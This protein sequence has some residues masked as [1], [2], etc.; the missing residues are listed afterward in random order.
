M[1]DALCVLSYLIFTTILEISYNYNPHF[2][3]KGTAWL[4]NVPEA[5]QL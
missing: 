3:D 4:N 5:I 1:L 2:I